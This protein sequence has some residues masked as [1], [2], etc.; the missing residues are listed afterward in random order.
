MPVKTL[1]GQI[2]I[3]AL[4]G[5]LALASLAAGAAGASDIKSEGIVLVGDIA[6][7]DVQGRLDH[8]TVDLAHS[9]LYLAA[10]GAGEVEV[11]D[12]AQARSGKRTERLRG[13]QEPQG[14]AYAPA[15]QQ[16]FVAAG[17]DG[18]V[19]TFRATRR[20]AVVSGLPDA[21]NMRMPEH[22][23]GLFV[24]FGSGLA[25]LDPTSLRV[26]QRIDL[27]GHPEAFE[28][29]RTG[30][31]IWVNVP[32][33]GR[34]VVVDRR[35]G[36]TLRQWSVS[37]ASGNFPMALDEADHR[38]FIGLRSPASLQVY[39]TRTG[40]RMGDVPL[41]G[42][43]DDLFFD[44]ERRQLYAICGDGRV[45]VLRERSDGRYE[46]TQRI[47]TA[48]GARTGLFVPEWK[49]LF[50]AAPARAGQSARVLRY[51]LP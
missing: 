29:S 24:G 4:G 1:P 49:A 15:T 10:L 20:M 42:D 21:D 7:P 38:L 6:L 44:R 41:C 46:T 28:L 17:G 16:L 34:V 3:A 5:L 25:L 51:R 19:T 9:R 23:G 37:P 48:P 33:A 22:D 35:S 12:V 47:G 18:A 32:D 14:L 27:P 8:F 43:V 40:Q 11:M 13:M 31:Q 2:G 50:V 45:D 39:D 26:Q 30:P 36:K